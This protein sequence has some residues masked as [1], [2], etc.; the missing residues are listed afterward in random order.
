M[1]SLSARLVALATLLLLTAPAI[2]PAEARYRCNTFAL[3]TLTGPLPWGLRV[4]GSIST[5]DNPFPPGIHYV[6]PGYMV[7]AHAGAES[8]SGGCGISVHTS[9]LGRDYT[10]GMDLVGQVDKNLDGMGDDWVGYWEWR[11]HQAI[12]PAFDL[13]GDG[14]LNVDEFR[15]NLVPI[16]ALATTPPAPAL[17][18]AQN[19]KD[20]EQDAATG[21]GGDGWEDGPEVHYWDD[22]SNNGVNVQAGVAFFDPDHSLDTDADGSANVNDPDADNDTLSD[23]VEFY[24]YGSY[25]EFFDS[26]C[27]LQATQCTAS[28][29]ST[30]ADHGRVGAPGTGDTIRDGDELS[31]WNA[32]GGNLWHTDFDGDGISSNLLDPDADGD[33]L[34]DGEEF[35][36]GSG[37]VRPDRVDTEGDG[38]HDK[39]EVAWNLDTDHDGLVNANDPDSDNDG[40]PDAW[41]VAHNFNMVDPT[42]AALDR[43]GDG[44][45]N[46]G[47]YQ[48][49]TNPDD[50]D[51]EGSSLEQGDHL[52]DGEEVNT[53]HS[54]PL[55][56]DTDRDGMADYFEVRTMTAS[57]A[58]R[59]APPSSSGPTWR[60]TATAA[61]PPTPSPRAAPGCWAPTPT[62][63]TPTRTAPR[64]ATKPTTAPMPSCLRT[65]TAT[66]TRTASTSPKKSATAPTPTTL[67]PT[68]T[69]CA[70]AVALPTASP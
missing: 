10:I 20:N 65:A 50:M 24:T 17:P 48:H 51:S 25:P 9:V 18:A 8:D 54:D 66:R 38:I 26:D 28:T 37:Q 6:P 42:D 68:L 57:T 19:C 21:A 52:L 59:T 40:M 56:W 27:T 36:L 39:D 44:L 30:Y 62:T 5:D 70:M 41:E 35:L 4:P 49:A 53:Y 58:T 60:N 34:L 3:E 67:I 11:A 12:D 46:L 13:D 2:P 47:E 15:W 23:G 22:T 55:H 63:P 32:L 43:D 45:T 64:T 33:G 7:N 1:N 69:A 61:P 14:L 31:A 29:S 16:C